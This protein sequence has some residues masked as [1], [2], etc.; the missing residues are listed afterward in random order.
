M[1]RIFCSR[2]RTLRGNRSQAD[3]AGFFGVKQQT[4]ARWENGSCEPNFETLRKISHVFGVSY[5]WL[6]EGDNIDTSHLRHPRC[7]RL[8]ADNP[9]KILGH[10]AEEHE[11]Y[12]EPDPCAACAELKATVQDL[13]AKNTELQKTVDRQNRILDKLTK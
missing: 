9:R 8:I 2:L 13:T 7:M 10:A 3:F 5:C 1:D 6:F 4:Y 11:P 12:G